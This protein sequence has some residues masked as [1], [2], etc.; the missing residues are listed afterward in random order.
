MHTT[1]TG[2]ASIYLLL[3]RHI[4]ANYSFFDFG[5]GFRLL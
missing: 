5:L 2:A 4:N 3:N 1:L